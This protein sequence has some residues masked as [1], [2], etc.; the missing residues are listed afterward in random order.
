MP[1]GELQSSLRREARPDSFHFVSFAS[2][3]TC[4]S[5]GRFGIEIDDA[6]AIA[7]QVDV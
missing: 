5:H 1:K 2:I 4:P 6:L 7:E 3:L